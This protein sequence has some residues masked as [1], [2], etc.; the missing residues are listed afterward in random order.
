HVDE[1]ITQ[2]MVR[3]GV[4]LHPASWEK[5]LSVAASALQK[6]GAKAAA[7]AG[8]E[9][10]NEEA[11]LLQRLFREGLG[12][13]HLASSPAGELPADVARALAAPALQATVADLEF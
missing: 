1:R 8:G 3:E 5:A 7:I 9:T 12:S 4:S 6:A 2:P 11:F 13:G 10:T